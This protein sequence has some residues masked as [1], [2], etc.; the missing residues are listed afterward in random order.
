MKIQQRDKNT[1]QLG[2]KDCYVTVKLSASRCTSGKV[3][4]ELSDWPGTGTIWNYDNY[5]QFVL[6]M[7]RGQPCKFYFNDKTS[8]FEVKNGELWVNIALHNDDTYTALFYGV[9]NQCLETD[10]TQH[11]DDFKQ[12]GRELDTA[13]SKLEPARTTTLSEL[14]STVE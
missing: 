7:S 3:N 11:V 9:I 2:F 13:L 5:K 14:F 4:Y 8:Y 12:F 1:F 10:C 6:D